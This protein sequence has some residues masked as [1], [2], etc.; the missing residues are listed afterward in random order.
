MS[1][2][3]SLLKMVEQV[4]YTQE[5]DEHIHEVTGKNKPY[6]SNMQANKNMEASNANKRTK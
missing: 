6:L 5:K 1:T 4:M 3:S 2:K